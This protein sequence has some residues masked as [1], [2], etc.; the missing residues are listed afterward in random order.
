MLLK[1]SPIYIA[2]EGPCCAGKTSLIAEL[3]AHFGEVTTIVAVPD[4]ADLVGGGD[5]MP[6]PDPQ[7]LASELAALDD[8]LKIE[9]RRFAEQ[10]PGGSAIALIDRS[11]LTLL[12]HCSGLQYKNNYPQSIV[13]IVEEVLRADG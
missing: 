9:E 5:G 13:P 11:V 6:D 8:L 10:R 2:I 12:G 3:L 7:D 4:M 1:K